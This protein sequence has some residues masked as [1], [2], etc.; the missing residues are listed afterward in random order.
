[1]EL[2]LGTSLATCSRRR[3]WRSEF[4]TVV[5][6]TPASA[7]IASIGRLQARRVLDL[8]GNDAED[9]ELAEREAGGDKQTA[10]SSI[11]G[12]HTFHALFAWTV[13]L[14]GFLCGVTRPYVH[15]SGRCGFR[16]SLG[17]PLVVLERMD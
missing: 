3:A 8:A 13:P 2:S 15:P 9:R 11:C 12:E 4:W 10:L 17:P 6:L 1:M 5:R 16:L 14:G 7:A